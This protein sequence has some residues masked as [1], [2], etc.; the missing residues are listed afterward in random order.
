MRNSTWHLIVIAIVIGI[1][2][3]GTEVGMDWLLHSGR[4]EVYASDFFVGAV[5]ALA[6]GVAMHAGNRRRRNLLLRMQ[7]IEDVN[8]HVRNALTAVTYSAALKNDAALSAVVKDANDRID[9][10]L[11]EVLPHSAEASGAGFRRSKWAGGAK[12]NSAER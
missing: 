8:H 2:V 6:S 12:V 11:R 9:W 4:R 7:A 1:L 3:A 5:A 10:V